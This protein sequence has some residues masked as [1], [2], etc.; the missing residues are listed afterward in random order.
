MRLPDD[1]GIVERYRK[2][3]GVMLDDGRVVAWGK[4]MSWRAILLAVHE[5]AYGDNGAQP[6]AAVFFRSTGRYRDDRTR[7]MVHDAASKLGVEEVV[8]LET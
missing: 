4:A 5:R 3:H 8:W 7:K 1:I 2:P 6:F